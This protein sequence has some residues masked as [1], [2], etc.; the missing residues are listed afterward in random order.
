[1]QDPFTYGLVPAAPD[2]E[3]TDAPPSPLPVGIATRQEKDRVVCLRAER[4]NFSARTAR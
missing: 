1:M 2:T 4:M 3:E